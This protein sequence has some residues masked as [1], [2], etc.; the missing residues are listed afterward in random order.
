MDFVKA[1][2]PLQKAHCIMDALFPI[3]KEKYPGFSFIFFLFVCL[4]SDAYQK[5][6]QRNLRHSASNVTGLKLLLLLETSAN[7][8]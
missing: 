4:I 8:L 5:D 1:T 6:L 2:R 7:K 3:G